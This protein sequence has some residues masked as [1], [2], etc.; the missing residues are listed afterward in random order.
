MV[1]NIL[2]WNIDDDNGNSVEDRLEGPGPLQLPGGGPFNDHDLEPAI[3]KV[4][5]LLASAWT[6]GAAGGAEGY[7]AGVTLQISHSANLALWRAQDK[8]PLDLTY[9]FTASG[10]PANVPD[11]IW[12]EGKELGTGPVSWELFAPTD[13]NPGGEVVAS[14][15]V[16][17]SVTNEAPVAVDDGPYYVGFLDTENPPPLIVAAPGV[18]SNDWDPDGDYPLSAVLYS[19]P[20]H[21]TLEYFNSNG[22]FKYVPD[23][24]F[25]GNDSF[26]YLA[27][28][29]IASSPS[30]GTARVTKYR[31]DVMLSDGQFGPEVPY[32]VEESRGAFTVANM[33]DTDGDGVTD[34]VDVDGVIATPAGRNEV[35]LMQLKIARPYRDFEGSVTLTVPSRDTSARSE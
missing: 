25:T 12:V 1:G 34:N 35:D 30:V 26:Q 32:P 22:S 7:L 29:G 11:E 15:V 33:N 16:N 27:N 9:S 20:S 4:D 2:A 6:S 19:G 31:V 8:E 5:D 10:P 14:D 13:A 24:G 3:L 18:L 17:F 23:P 28:D 21:G